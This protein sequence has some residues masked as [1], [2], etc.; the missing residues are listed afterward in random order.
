MYWKLILLRIFDT[1]LDDFYDS[2]DFIQYIDKNEELAEEEKFNQE[3]SKLSKEYYQFKNIFQGIRN[4]DT[5]YPKEFFMEIE[6]LPE[7]ELPKLV[8]LYILPPL[9]RK[10]V[11]EFLDFG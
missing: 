4:P 10:A 5:L 8:K 3:F 11:D 9:H 6:L 2:E 1:Y 7:K